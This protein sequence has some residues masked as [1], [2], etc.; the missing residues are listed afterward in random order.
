[1]RFIPPAW[2]IAASGSL[3][4]W[5]CANSAVIEGQNAGG[6]SGGGGAVSLNPDAST[7]SLKSD[8]PI[9]RLGLDAPP[10]PGCGNGVLTKDEACDDGNNVSGD[11]C[12]ANCLSVEPGFSCVTPGQPCRPIA[13][14]GDGVVVFPEQC[15]DGN[16]TAGDGCSDSCKI[17]IGFKCTVGVSSQNPSVCTPTTCGDGKKE[18]A[19]A[20][21]DGN[22]MPFDGCSSDC[23]NEPSC[24][25][26]GPCTSTCGDGIVLNEECDDGNNINGDGC[27]SDCKIEKGFNCSQP[28]LGNTMK[29]PVIYRD[30]RFHNPTDF[31]SGTSGSY[32]AF[33]GMVN[34][35][36][37]GNGKPVYSGI[38]GNAHVLSASSFAEWY[39]DTPGVNH[40]TPSKMT[41][42]DNGQ[43]A[44]VNRYGPN[45]Q[46]WN[47][48][49]IAYYC[50]NVGREKVD[51]AGNPIPCTSIDPNPTECDTMIAAG[52]TLLTCSTSNGSYSATIIVAKADGNPLFFP[53]D[54]DTFTPASEL[55]PATIPPYYDATAS[56]PFDLDAS[57][58]KRLHNFSFT[59]EVRYWFLYK[60]ATS[61]TLDFVGDDDV[62]VFI[63]GKLAVDLG[64]VHTPMDGSI[65]IGA[66]GNGTTTITQTYP[67]PAPA[68]TQQSTT[69]GLQD[70]Q[71]Y[72]IAVFQ[73]ERQ[74]TGSSYKLT[75]SGF[76]AAPSLCK[77]ICGDGILS[78][79]EECD[80][81]AANGTGGYG[82]CGADCTLGAF[83]GDGVVQPGE[84]CDDGGNNGF[85]GYCPSGC[86]I[87]VVF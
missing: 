49:K 45:G 47:T 20:C 75:L 53:V 86:R 35:T 77:P 40:S 74:T 25:T 61:Y 33:Q 23:Q 84:D 39:Q 9:S 8:G 68:S 21:D 72:E 24:K 38:S 83:C 54:G 50:G 34:A 29:V 15:D 26:S 56:W 64:G 67:I 13:R 14:C 19:E 7:I 70:G 18:G 16:K 30:F 85:P 66:N 73:A 36:L 10:A 11:G 60:K 55:Q 31:E 43:S 80:D 22:D 82:T 59:S 4:I 3:M 65:V 71:V 87:I 58:A 46:Q 12:A 28:P 78:I 81:G 17:E 52:G 42:W 6:N 37:D 41:L 76:N 69:L 48:T 79:G 62:W 32:A 2:F 27:S 1:M 44:F 51:A 57:G 5:G 63:N